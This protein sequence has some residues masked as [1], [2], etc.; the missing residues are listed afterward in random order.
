M[1]VPQRSQLAQTAVCITNKLVKLFLSPS[2]SA[3]RDENQQFNPDLISKSD[4][5]SS[6]LLGSRSCAKRQ[7]TTTAS[8]SAIEAN[9]D[10]SRDRAPAVW[11]HGN[12]F[13]RAGRFDR[14]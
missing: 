6:G 3:Q 11:R 14:D 1:A 13:R 4:F 7:E 8:R 10:A 5:S 2:Q 12:S 9:Y